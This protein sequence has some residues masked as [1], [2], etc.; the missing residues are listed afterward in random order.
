[1]TCST[2]IS[3][4]PKVQRF[5]RAY[6]RSYI[7][8]YFKYFSRLYLGQ[9]DLP[10]TRAIS[11][12]EI[13]IAKVKSESYSALFISTLLVKLEYRYPT[14]QAPPPCTSSTPPGRALSLHLKL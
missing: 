14:L 7:Y 13:Q 1:M 10:T 11:Y 8:A 6:A 12:L 9:S 2:L 4:Y 3:N 5:A